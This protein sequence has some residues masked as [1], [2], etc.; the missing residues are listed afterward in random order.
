LAAK[1]GKKKP[2]RTVMGVVQFE[3]D[4]REIGDDEI[5]VRSIVVR[6]TGFKQN[7][8]NVSGTLWPSHS[9]VEVEKGDVVIMEG[10]FSQTTG[11]N[12]EGDEITYHN[13]SISAIAV[14]GSVD[15]GVRDDDDEDEEPKPKRKTKA[16]PKVDAEDDDDVPF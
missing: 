11:E 16:K 10:P 5:P 3:P 7:A 8:V 6:Q 13:L 1:K 9:H 15:Y 2:Y 4:E 12:K 14:I